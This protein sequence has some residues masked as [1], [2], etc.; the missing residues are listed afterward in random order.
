MNGIMIANQHASSS[1]YEGLC[2]EVAPG[3]AWRMEESGFLSNKKLYK[4][5]CHL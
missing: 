1:R 4:Y 2:R 3:E 5:D